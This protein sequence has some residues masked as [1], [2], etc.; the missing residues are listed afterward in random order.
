[1][2]KYLL[3]VTFIICCLHPSIP[4]LDVGGDEIS[5]INHD[6]DGFHDNID[7]ILYT[8]RIPPCSSLTTNTSRVLETLGD[9]WKPSRT[10]PRPSENWLYF[11]C[12]VTHFGAFGTQVI[13][14]IGTVMHFGAS[15]IQIIGWAR[16]GYRSH[17]FCMFSDYK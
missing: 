9:P 14:F 17:C 13:G 12:I 3:L 7:D 1:M 10:A 2:I 16:G 6:I 5:K 4:I 15:G 8:H 11:F